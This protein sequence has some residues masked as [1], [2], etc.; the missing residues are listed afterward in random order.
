MDMYTNQIARARE[1]QF[2]TGG[3]RPINSGINLVNTKPGYGDEARAVGGALSEIFIKPRVEAYVNKYKM[4]NDPAILEDRMLKALENYAKLPDEL[5]EMIRA[6][7]GHQ[8]LLQKF[9]NKVPNAT[10]YINRRPDDTLEFISRA[11]TKEE[12]EAVEVPANSQSERDLRAAQKVYYESESDKIRRGDTPHLM[13]LT[14]TEKQRPGLIQAEIRRFDQ[15]SAESKAREEKVNA[16]AKALQ[17]QEPW[18]IPGIKAEIGLKNAQAYNAVQQ[19]GYYSRMPDTQAQAGLE[20]YKAKIQE[21]KDVI[22]G[23]EMQKKQIDHDTYVQFGDNP[24]LDKQVV[25]LRRHA[26]DAIGVAYKLGSNNDYARGEAA[27]S[28][29]SLYGGFVAANATKH[30]TKLGRQWF[31]YEASMKKST[32]LMRELSSYAAQQFDIFGP[33]LPKD[34]LQKVMFMDYLMRVKSGELRSVGWTS[35]S[36]IPDQVLM[37]NLCKKFGITDPATI[38]G[39]AQSWTNIQANPNPGT[40]VERNRATVGG[41]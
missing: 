36:Q 33:Y 37:A 25:G 2:P 17:I 38:N 16:E 11:K 23:H 4:E 3:Q 30:P 14:E 9:V 19:G 27:E 13:A 7:Q 41:N 39:I 1:L 26:Q 10:S 18:L 6:N 28:I 34:A 5:K 24:P 40:I 35:P 21:T 31:G 20:S 22:K 8:D 15:E 12:R 29:D 32:G